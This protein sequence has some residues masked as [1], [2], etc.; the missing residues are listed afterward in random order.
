[1]PDYAKLLFIINILRSWGVEFYN[2]I[3]LDACLKLSLP[4]RISY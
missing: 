2:I 3:L 1:M 4:A